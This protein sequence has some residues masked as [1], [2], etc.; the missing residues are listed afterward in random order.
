VLLEQRQSEILA[1]CST[2]KERMVG[3]YVL[4]MFV[5]WLFLLPLVFFGMMTWPIFVTF[6]VFSLIRR[7]I[8]DKSHG[9]FAAVYTLRHF[10]MRL[11]GNKS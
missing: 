4:R 10:N 1:A 6:F 9:E 7:L 3:A 5:P 2:T 11:K 8:E